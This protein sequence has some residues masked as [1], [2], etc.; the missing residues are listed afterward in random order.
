MSAD[1]Q[2][3]ESVKRMVVPEWKVGHAVAIPSPP[4]N[5][6]AWREH[7]CAGMGGSDV[8]AILGLSKWSTRHS[9]YLEKA[10]GVLPRVSDRP[11]VMDCGRELERLALRYLADETELDVQAAN[12][13]M[14][15]CHPQWD[16]QRAHIDGFVVDA[17]EASSIV[18]AKWAQSMWYEVPVYYLCQA[19]WYLHV[20]G[21]DACYF[22]VIFA[23]RAWDW[24]L[25]ERDEEDIEL[26][27]DASRRFWQRHVVEGVA[28]PLDGSDDARRMQI[29]RAH[30]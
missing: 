19:Q 15:L 13:D 7:R 2:W 28:P 25:V 27:V 8:A 14:T 20:T 30:V 18:E 24:W 6:Q 16:W 23:N 9:V 3:D 5:T 21:L 12:D 11:V 4:A 17:G 22:T 29:G 10:R 1:L 26:I